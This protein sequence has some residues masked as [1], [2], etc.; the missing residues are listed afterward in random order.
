MPFYIVYIR[1]ICPRQGA[2]PAFTLPWVTTFDEKNG[3]WHFC[4]DRITKYV[5]FN[6]NANSL[7]ILTDSFSTIS[8]HPN[9]HFYRYWMSL[10]EILHYKNLIIERNATHREI[11][12]FLREHMKFLLTYPV[13]SRRPLC[14]ALFMVLWVLV[15][16]ILDMTCWRHQMETFSA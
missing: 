5:L 13:G 14:W 16:Y 9:N 4:D 12:L 7:E 8:A 15:S 1:L 2:W 11:K 6:T 10:N 3:T